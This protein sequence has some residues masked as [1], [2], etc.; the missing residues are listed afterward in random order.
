MYMIKS[1]KISCNKIGN[2]ILKKLIKFEMKQSSGL[3]ENLFL[4]ILLEGT[5]LLTSMYQT[6]HRSLAAYF[7]KT[8]YKYRV[9]R[10]NQNSEFQVIKSTTY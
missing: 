1:S 5:C 9:F 3:W 4:D 8:L 7:R 2:T 6:H 10:K